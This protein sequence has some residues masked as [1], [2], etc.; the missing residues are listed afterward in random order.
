M[1]K[2]KITPGWLALNL[3]SIVM[4]VIYLAPVV[5]AFFV[6]LQHEG[7]QIKSI[8]SW[9]TPPYTLEN[10]P[11]I[12]MNSQVPT[13]LF[14][15]IFISVVS[16]V[17]T[18]IV[19]SMAA[20]AIAKIP[21]KGS[22]W[23]FLFFLLGMMVPG[24]ATIVPLFITV[25]KLKLIDTYAG[26]ILPGIAG[27]MNLIIMTSFFKGIP[28]EL[29]EA[30]KIDGGGY[31]T[32]FTKIIVPLSKTILSTVCIFSFIGSWNSYL[33]PLLCAMSSE[34]F[35]LPIGVPTFAGTYTVDYVLPLTASMVASLPMLIIY[36]I[37]EKRIVSGIT[38]G[39]IKG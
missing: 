38:L 21:F 2:K 11:F 37:F 23:F 27:S 8:F 13:W 3:I 19:T 29:L 9:F 17:L 35:T 31:W 5:F 39:A 14:N 16:T 20:Y 25:N 10:Y 32:M 18:L 24:E 12:I 4:A 33:W 30:V 22:R 34:M 15:S 1:R 26:L 36:I 28:D 6:S 7:K